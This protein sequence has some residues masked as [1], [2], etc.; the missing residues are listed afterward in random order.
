MTKKNTHTNSVS[1]FPL[2]KTAAEMATVVGIGENKLRELMDKG[3]LEYLPIGN[4]RLL[5]VQAVQDYY[6]RHKVPVCP[7]A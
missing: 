3:E 5:T 2:F 1:P 7:S 4:R 6:A